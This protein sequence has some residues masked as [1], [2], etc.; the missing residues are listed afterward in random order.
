MDIKLINVNS[1]NIDKEKYDASNFIFDL[2]EEINNVAYIKLGSIEIPITAY[3]FLSSKKN[4]SFKIGDGVN[5]DTVTI[6]DGNYTTDS[7]I[8]VIQTHLDNIN[9]TRSKNYAID[10]NTING[11][12]FFTSD[13][14]MNLD[15]SSDSE[16]GSLGYYMGFTEDSYTGTRVDADCV[17]H[18][19][20]PLYYFLNIN[21][22]NNLQDY[23]VPNVFA[24]LIKNV[25]SYDYLIEGKGDFVTKEM[26]FRSPINL[27]KLKVQLLD[28]KGNIINLNGNNYSFTLEVGY[29]YDKRLYEQINNGGVP[30]GDNRTKF[31]Y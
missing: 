10:I 22:F 28:F 12:M 14:S 29:I 11:K 13:D 19:H 16:Y 5:I 23:N 4:V 8:V 31:F 20:D 25:G 7:L 30:N 21:D 26:V 27:N 9:T 3:T 18:L 15:F 1:R 24:K 17:V 2:D 6:E